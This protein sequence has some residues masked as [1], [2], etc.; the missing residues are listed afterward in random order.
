MGSTLSFVILNTLNNSTFLTS[1]TD[2]GNTFTAIYIYYER[3]KKEKKKKKKKKTNL[4][5]ISFIFN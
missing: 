3:I 1:T 5:N 2:L 4:W